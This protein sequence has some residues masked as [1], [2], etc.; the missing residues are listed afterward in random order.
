MKKLVLHPVFV[1]L[2]FYFSWVVLTWDFHF[3]YFIEYFLI[4]SLNEGAKIGKL[5][6]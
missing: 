4:I 2:V 3:W 6:R 1:P 5:L